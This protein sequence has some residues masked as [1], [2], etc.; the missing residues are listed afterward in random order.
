MTVTWIEGR[1]KCPNEVV[2]ISPMNAQRHARALPPFVVGARS[3]YPTV[4]PA[5]NTRRHMTERE[6]K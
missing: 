5:T 6:R 1:K 2:S 3:P 4:V